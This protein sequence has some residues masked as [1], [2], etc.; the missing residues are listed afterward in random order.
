MGTEHSSNAPH[1]GQAA[2]L[3]RELCQEKADHAMA[4]AGWDGMTAQRDRIASERD[5]ALA[6]RD[7]L[8]DALADAA[9]KAGEYAHWARG[10][11]D[12]LRD[13]ARA[14]LLVLDRTTFSA[15]ALKGPELDALRRACGD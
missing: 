8:R 13:A 14:F 15:V 3:Y 9:Q 1:E 12:R 4:L 11:M 10:E 2:Q 5:A 6:E 7:R